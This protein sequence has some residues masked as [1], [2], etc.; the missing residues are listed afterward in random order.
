MRVSIAAHDNLITVDGV[1]KTV[2]CSA[3]IAAEISAIQWYN[4]HGEIEFIGHKKI[5]ERITNF[6]KY[7]PLINAAQSLPSAQP[8][9]MALPKLAFAD[10]ALIAAEMEA[11]EKRVKA[12]KA[13]K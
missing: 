9:G 4:D 5:N 13:K 1:T 10:P 7:A 6:D 12:Q 11:I 2:N 8:G 3:L